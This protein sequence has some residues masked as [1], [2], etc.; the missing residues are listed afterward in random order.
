MTTQR[1][2]YTILLALAIVAVLIG[3]MVMFLGVPLPWQVTETQTDTQ[4]DEETPEVFVQ[5]TPPGGQAECAAGFSFTSECIRLNVYVAGTTNVYDLTTAS[6][7]DSLDLVLSGDAT[8]GDLRIGRIRIQFNDFDYYI[9]AGDSD[10]VGV[11]ATGDDSDILQYQNGGAFAWAD[12]YRDGNDFVF[13]NFT[14]PQGNVDAIS[15]QG[16]VSL[17]A[18]NWVAGA[19]N[20]CNASSEILNNA[21]CVD[22]VAS[23]SNGYPGDTINFTLTGSTNN[24]T[25][26][27]QGQYTV[28]ANG[29]GESTRVAAIDS[30]DGLNFTFSYTVPDDATGNLSFQGYL[31][32]PLGEF[33]GAACRTN[34]SVNEITACG[35]SCE[36][37]TDCEG[38][39]VCITADNGNGYCAMDNEDIKSA[40]GDNPT[41]SNCCEEE[42]EIL[43]CG[44]FGCNDNNDCEGEAICITAD[45]GA[46][47]CSMPAYQDACGDN[48]TT[49]N[50]CEEQPPVQ[51]ELPRAGSVPPTLI[52][53]ITGV[54][55]VG[56]GLLF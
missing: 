3:G 2:I 54:I 34:V 53:T 29:E 39:L 5:T 45:N 6:P 40:C 35:T 43:V 1:L 32:H 27:S 36:T 14:I 9:V 33:D 48:P 17:D 38:S 15:L 47:Y 8:G 10:L 4:L 49:N 21:E 28:N 22:L 25:T 44:Q 30:G 26:F 37:D 24:Q 52:F 50:C 23:A 20:V 18:T 42:E 55:L 31:T 7:G 56:L 19:G 41:Y 13:P 16:A 11:Y 12:G 46:K 51:P